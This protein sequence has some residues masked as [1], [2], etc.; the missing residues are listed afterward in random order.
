MIKISTGTYLTSDYSERTYKQPASA[1]KYAQKKGY[2]FNY[3]TPFKWSYQGKN[4]K[5]TTS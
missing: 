5:I 4:Y 3:I 2:P 1:L